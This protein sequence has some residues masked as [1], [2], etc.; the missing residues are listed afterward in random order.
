MTTLVASYLNFYTKHTY[1]ATSNLYYS[2]NVIF[3]LFI[4]ASGYLS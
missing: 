2:P 4:I 1:K 3:V